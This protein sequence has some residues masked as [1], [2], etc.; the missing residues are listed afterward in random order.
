MFGAAAGFASASQNGLADSAIRAG[1]DDFHVGSRSVDDVKYVN[2]CIRRNFQ[3][4]LFL[5]DLDQG[6]LLRRIGDQNQRPIVKL[7]SDFYANAGITHHIR[8]PAS[9]YSC[10]ASGGNV[11]LAV[12]GE[13][14]NCY[15]VREQKSSLGL[16]LDVRN[17]LKERP[18]GDRSG[19]ELPCKPQTGDS[20]VRVES[21]DAEH[22]QQQGQAN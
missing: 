14:I 1:D 10:G 21:G 19:N 13:T 4:V 7:V 3:L 12:V 6:F 2:L 18:I 9:L 5:S 22:D 17:V 16:N 8:I 20:V 15:R 11:K